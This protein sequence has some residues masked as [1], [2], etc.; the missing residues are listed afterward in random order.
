MKKALSL[1]ICA[2]MLVSMTVFA[3]SAVNYEQPFD[4]GTLNVKEYRI[5]ALYTLE[6][7][8]V[9]AGADMRYDHGSDSPNNID[10]AVA[11]S[12]DGYTGWEYNVI[13]YFDD[14]A[15]GKTGTDSA[16]YIDSAI[17]QSK[18]TDRIFVLAD[19]YP[20]GGGWKPSGAET[21]FVDIDGEKCLLLTDGDY[22]GDIDAFEYYLGKDGVVYNKADN[23]ATEYTVDAEYRLYKNGAALMMDQKGAEGVKVQQNVFYKEAELSCYLT[24][25]LCIRYSDDNGETWSAPQLISAQVKQ[26]G[27]TFIGTAPGRGI[28]T[29]LADGTERIIFCV[30]DNTGLLGHDPIFENASTIYSDDNGATWHR[31]EETTIVVGIQKTSEAQ[32]VELATQEDGMPVLRMYARNGSNYIAYADSYDGGI[33]WTTFV[34]DEALQG[35]KNCMYSFINTS[36]EI[37]GKKVILSSAGGNLDKRA[38]GIVRVGLV[39]STDINNIKVEW[40]TKYRVE[41]GF[42]GYSCLTELA[43][44][45]IGYLYEDEASHIR[46]MILALDE[47]G[48]LTEI[49]GNNFE[50]TVKLTGWQK[51]VK[52]FKDLFN[53]I[54]AWFG[55]I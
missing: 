19:I 52:F 39:D 12:E 29:T 15:D 41:P 3:A 18:K 44:G 46:Y 26:K 28:V 47:E 1:L 38:D 16:S 27:E 45:N 51:F 50:G 34:R 14:Y 8:A 23:T 20:S 24:S 53:N 2:L 31:G 17:V 54:L 42:F 9:I 10:I 30:Y 48:N 36:K 37:D 4:R 40:I 35:T 43:D 7:G 13:N 5:P 21:G 49:N 22:A 32:I 11:V 55:L 6:N 33:S 25:Y